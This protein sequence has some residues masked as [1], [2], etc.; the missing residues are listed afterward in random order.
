[1]PGS[2]RRH[3]SLE[4]KNHK[5]RSLVS[6][7]A[8]PEGSSR[9]EED[10][11]PAGYTRGGW[12]RAVP[13]H[14]LP[15]LQVRCYCLFSVIYNKQSTQLFWKCLTFMGSI[16]VS[17]SCHLATRDMG[18]GLRHGLMPRVWCFVKMLWVFSAHVQ[19]RDEPRICVTS[20]TELEGSLP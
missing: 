4:G 8:G 13:R 1:M 2:P 16:P 19:S 12:S 3:R 7:S 11:L 9:Q 20:H 17:L 10:P 5:Q 18:C 15:H 14:V 6:Q